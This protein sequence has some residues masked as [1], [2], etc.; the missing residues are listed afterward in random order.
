MENNNNKAIKTNGQ[1]ATPFTQTY[2]HWTKAD[3]KISDLIQVG[4]NYNFSPN[5]A[6]IITQ[7][8]KKFF[9]FFR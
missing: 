9:G 5:L 4:F 8:G 1:G 3:L 2:F 6:K 7:F